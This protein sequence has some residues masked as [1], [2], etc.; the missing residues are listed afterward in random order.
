MTL[1][2][3]LISRTHKTG[4]VGTWDRLFYFIGESF[5]DRAEEFRKPL[6]AVAHG[7][8]GS[9]SAPFSILTHG[10]DG[11]PLGSSHVHPRPSLCLC[12]SNQDPHGPRFTAPH[13][14]AERPSL[15]SHVCTRADPGSCPGESP[16]GGCV[17][18]GLPQACSQADVL[19]ALL[20]SPGRLWSLSPNSRDELY[21]R[22]KYPCTCRRSCHLSEELFAVGVRRSD[23]LPGH[24]PLQSACEK[25]S[26]KT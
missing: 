6:D 5:T 24:F 21:V 23:Y 11:A 4:F 10:I 17:P 16:L 2:V 14:V 13:E 19:R 12:C 15:R 26:L 3:Q 9:L 22:H 7:A 8:S 25:S 20:A 1:F 18:P